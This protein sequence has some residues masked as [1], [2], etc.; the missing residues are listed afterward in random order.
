MCFRD[1]SFTISGRAQPSRAVWELGAEHRT[2]DPS[3]SPGAFTTSCD[4]IRSS[5]HPKRTQPDLTHTFCELLH[6]D[7]APALS[8]RRRVSIFKIKI[9]DSARL[10][11]PK[12]SF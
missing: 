5:R 1:N 7:V 8:A 6:F 2:V 9:M 11:A 4:P 12:Q 3:T 10:S